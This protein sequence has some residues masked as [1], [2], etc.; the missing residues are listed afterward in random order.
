M[1]GLVNMAKLMDLLTWQKNNPTF[2]VPSWTNTSKTT[3]GATYE[4]R[5]KRSQ[6]CLQKYRR[7]FYDN[8]LLRGIMLWIIR[9]AYISFGMCVWNA[10][11]CILFLTSDVRTCSLLAMERVEVFTW[12]NVTHFLFSISEPEMFKII[13]S[14][15]PN[16]LN[17]LIFVMETQ[18]VVYDARS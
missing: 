18:S 7:T 5:L 9:K 8:A 3:G 14:I 15:F 17:W 16:R 12:H 6:C 13:I 2:H 10:E 11:W 4:L 1:D